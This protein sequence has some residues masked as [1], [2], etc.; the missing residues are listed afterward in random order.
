VP[1]GDAGGSKAENM[2]QINFRFATRWRDRQRQRRTGRNRDRKLMPEEKK[3]KS[4][5]T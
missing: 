3:P 4:S 5:S 2:R 1:G